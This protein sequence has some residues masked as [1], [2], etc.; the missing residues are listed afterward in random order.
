MN[1]DTEEN[2]EKT[3]RVVA[4]IYSLRQR[5]NYHLNAIVGELII[6]LLCSKDPLS[7]DNLQS[8]QLQLEKAV[9]PMI[10]TLKI[11]VFTVQEQVALLIPHQF[12]VAPQVVL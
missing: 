10:S 7:L 4:L 12:P 2:K 3:A 9:T 6:L 8:F 11:L 1:R 5:L